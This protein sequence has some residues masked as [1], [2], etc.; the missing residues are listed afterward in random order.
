MV[1]E[2]RDL[3]TAEIAVR[4]ALVGRLLISTLHTNDA[5]GAVPR[6]LDMGIEP[7]LVASTLSLVAAQR[8]VRRICSTCRES[9]APDP[10]LL[11]VL[12]ARADF[13]QMVQVLRAEGVIGGS[14]DPFASAR[15][16][17]G[18]GCVQCAGTGFRS[19]LG[20]FELLEVTDAIRAM[21][22]DRKD[23]TAIRAEATRNGTMVQDGIAK[24][25]LGETTLEEVFR[26]A[27]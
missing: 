6:L 8:L 3:E 4:S 7:F 11:K 19:R 23:A 18:K 16:F 20:I 15:V 17:R 27:L 9:T 1:G 25:L 26:V 12:Y 22:M 14:D 21:I 5:T 2:I 10:T 24:A 13:E